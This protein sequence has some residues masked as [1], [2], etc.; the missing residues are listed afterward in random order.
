MPS[1]LPADGAWRGWCFSNTVTE[2]FPA[3]QHLGQ[4]R[5]QYQNLL[6]LTLLLTTMVNPSLQSVSPLEGE[7]GMKLW[8]GRQMFLLGTLQARQ[9]CLFPGSPPCSLCERSIKATRHDIRTFS[10]NPVSPSQGW[11]STG[12]H[13]VTQNYQTRIK[14]LYLAKK[15]PHFFA[16]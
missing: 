13:L 3:F 14:T 9:C 8:S 4:R 7:S 5:K 16:R 11:C 10:L 15:F 2:R 1:H 6:L 12:H